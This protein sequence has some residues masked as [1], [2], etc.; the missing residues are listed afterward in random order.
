M[1]YYFVGI[2][3]SGMAALAQI[4]KDLGNEVAG[5]DT[6]TLLFTEIP[7]REKQILIEPLDDMHFEDFDIIVIG[8]AFLEKYKFN[9]KETITYQELLSLIADKYYSIAVCGTHGKT[10]ITNMIRHV[11]SCADNV[12]YLVGDGTGRAFKDSKYFVFEACEHKE[13]FL[14]YYPDMIVCDNIE[15]DHVE[16]YQNKRKYKQAFDKFFNKAQSE[17]VLNKCIK[18]KKEK[19]TYGNKNA[20][21]IVKNSHFT[22][23]NTV[24]SLIVEGKEYKNISVPFFGKHM[25]NNTLCTV[26][27]CYKLGVS[28]PM[29]IE[30]L[31]TY[32]TAK[33]RYNKLA[34]GSN[35][36]ID[37]YG[38]HPTEIK[39]TITA[40]KQEYPNKQIIVFYHPDRPKRL[41]AFLYKYQSVFNKCYKTYVLPFLTDGKEETNALISLIDDKKIKLYSDK[42]LN[43]KYENTVFLLTGSKEMNNIK[44][45]LT[46]LYN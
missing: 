34:L 42:I 39:A 11:L 3:G 10:T 38:H 37:D 17:L 31:Q 44:N 28:V 13:H 23:K 16:Y 21:I 41:T 7:L 26:A 12:S 4:I 29:I 1:K 43:T 19:F 2:K 14:T 35:V 27:V 33:R 6:Q 5:A 8:N 24:F 32:T 9:N 45:K 25:L 36:L 15:L 46:E 22:D 30:K 40:I 18:S 20:D